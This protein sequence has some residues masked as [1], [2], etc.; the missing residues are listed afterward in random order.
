[1]TLQELLALPDEDFLRSVYVLILGREPDESGLTNYR[2]QL[3]RGVSKKAIVAEVAE[4]NEARPR[5]S[6]LDLA[7]LSDNDFLDAIYS[8]VLGRSPDAEG[9]HHYLDRLR[10]NADRRRIIVSLENSDEALRRDPAAASFRRELNVLLRRERRRPRWLNWRPQEGPAEQIRAL[11]ATIEALS[12]AQREEMASIREQIGALGAAVDE[13]SKLQGAALAAHALSL[14]EILETAT[15]TRDYVRLLIAA[16][17]GMA[18]AKGVT[19]AK[20]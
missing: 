18:N 19:T 6:H 8:R 5:Y 10:K 7:Q 12:K 13:L 2:R 11:G 1:M 9:K 4:S 20:R 17:E 15:A 14:K 3:G 16:V